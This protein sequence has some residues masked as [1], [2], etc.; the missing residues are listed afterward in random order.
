MALRFTARQL[1]SQSKRCEKQAKKEKLKLKKAIEQGNTEGARIYAQNAIRQK[2]QALNYLRLSSRVD[3]VST[4]VETAARMRQV[5]RSMN[6]IVVA[7]DRAMKEMN[8]EKM[9]QVLD[10]FEK[11]FEDM[12]VQTEYM[13]QTINTSTALTTPQAEVDDLISQV[14]AEHGL[15][16]KEELGKIAPADKVPEVDKSATEEQDILSQRLAKLKQM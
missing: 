6:N 8:L 11:Q 7:M 10:E 12:D 4:R 2:N 16:L 14:A 5:T 3:A 15:E 13:E 1:V 9:T